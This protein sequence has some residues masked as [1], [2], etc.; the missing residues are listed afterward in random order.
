MVQR[1]IK[2]EKQERRR[3]SYADPGTMPLVWHEGEA[4]ADFGEAD[5][6]VDGETRRLRYLNLS[7]PF[8]NKVFTVVVLERTANAYARG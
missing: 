5:F 6:I 1:F 2:E 3:M 7:F 8:S 4:Q